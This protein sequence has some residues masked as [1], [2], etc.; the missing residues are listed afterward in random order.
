MEGRGLEGRI[1]NI[2]GMG[3]VENRNI[4]HAKDA[5]LRWGRRDTKGWEGRRAGW[6]ERTLSPST[7]STEKLRYKHDSILTLICI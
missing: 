3:G 1:E 4:R 2:L 7:L 6:R 5:P